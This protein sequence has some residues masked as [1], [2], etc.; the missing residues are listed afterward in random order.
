VMNL[1]AHFMESNIGGLKELFCLKGL[2]LIS[3]GPI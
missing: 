2:G 1:F 3:A